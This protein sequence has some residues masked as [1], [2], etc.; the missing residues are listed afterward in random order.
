MLEGWL[1]RV[2]LH[3]LGLVRPKP[4]ALWLEE[5]VGW[6]AGSGGRGGMAASAL[7][8][9]PGTG[10]VFSKSSLSL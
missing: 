9:L 3:Q 1:P 6:S 4:G 2:G 10:S 5:E 7:G 8:M